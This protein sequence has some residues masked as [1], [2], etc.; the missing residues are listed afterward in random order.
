MLE[1]LH[2]FTHYETDEGRDGGGVGCE[3][4]GNKIKKFLDMSFQEIYRTYKSTEKIDSLMKLTF[5]LV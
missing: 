1:N 4:Y 2:P 5:R 3:N